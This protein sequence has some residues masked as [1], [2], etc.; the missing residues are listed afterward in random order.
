MLSSIIPKSLWSR[1]RECFSVIRFAV[2]I[3]VAG[4]G[5]AHAHPGGLDSNGGHYNRKTGEY[6]YHRPRATSTPAPVASPP[7]KAPTPVASPSIQP[8][9]P[10]PA[11]VQS[12][13]ADPEKPW[14][15]LFVQHVA[16]GTIDDTTNSESIDVLT[17][18]H[19]V[20][21]EQLSN[22]AVGIANARRKARAAAKPV[23]LVLYSVDSRD[24]AD[25]RADAK[26]VCESRGVTV[27]F[28]D[29]YVAG[30]LPNVEAADPDEGTDAIIGQPNAESTLRGRVVSVHDGD[31]ITVLVGQ[32]SIKVR[33]FGID[34]PELGG[35]PFGQAAKQ[36]LSER[37]FGRDVVIQVEGR[38]RYGRAIGRVFVDGRL[39]NAE[40][41]GAGMAW[42]YEQYAKDESNLKQLQEQ[43]RAEHMGLWNDPAPVAPWIWRKENA[44]APKASPASK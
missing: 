20:E 27:W 43:A 7:P 30:A 40:L 25:L 4:A 24:T 18:T 3:A 39:V 36:A 10:R 5:L 8:S 44:R 28:L 41:V 2:L 6:H 34:A 13:V 33:L 11:P 23:G 17:S 38:D 31:T 37:V 22:Y 19:A 32:S 35:Q 15:V 9:T 12:L 29:D 26:T 21:V 16:A 14:K 1:L 42:W